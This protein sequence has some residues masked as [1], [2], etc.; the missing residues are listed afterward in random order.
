MN[1][2]I[3]FKIVFVFR[4]CLKQQGLSISENN[5]LFRSNQNLIHVARPTPGGLSHLANVA[6]VTTMS[7]RGNPQINHHRGNSR[8]ILNN[9][10][11]SPDKDKLV[12]FL[13]MCFCKWLS[14]FFFRSVSNQCVGAFCAPQN[15]FCVCFFLSFDRSLHDF[16]LELTDF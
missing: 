3:F 8:A 7:Q 10:F 14:F 2:C 15:P 4:F 11:I 12:I 16:S 5:N 6:D 9:E 1:E 13:F